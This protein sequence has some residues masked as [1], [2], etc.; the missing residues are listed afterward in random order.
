[1]GGPQ[2][3][4]EL[5]GLARRRVLTIIALMIL[6]HIAFSGGRLALSLFAIELKATAF[7]VGAVV[8]LLS[9][10]P[11]FFSVQVGRWSDRIGIQ[12]PALLATA[13]VTAGILLPGVAPSIAAICAASMLV[14]SGFMILH[15]ATNNAVGHFSTPETRTQ[16]F[17]W[18][19][20]GFSVSTV[21]GPVIAGYA[22][23]HLGHARACLVLSVFPCLALMHY[24]LRPF[25]PPDANHPHPAANHGG[26][27]E[28]LLDRRIRSV[29][30]VSG[31]LNMSWDMF[32]FMFP[33]Y[34][35]S[36]RLSASNIGLVMGS[37]GVATF[38]V[39]LTLP[40]LFRRMG[41]WQVL[42]LGLASAALSFALFPFLAT[43]PT[44]MALSFILGLG[45]GATQ[46]MVLS[47]IHKVA[48]TG[49]TG[50]AIGL[51]TSLLNASQVFLPLIFG[52]F[53]AA[54]GMLPAFAT[55]AVIGAW[56]SWFARNTRHRESLETAPIS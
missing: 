19:A 34:G 13:L 55:M 28:L 35:A 8:S 49:R 41:E 56:G 48:P 7:V 54:A 18:L 17:S 31:L 39:R 9:L 5:K 11:M 1:M 50:E 33:V 23:D 10:L 36:I 2:P 12:R 4:G 37:F 46:P 15:I 27:R 38:V 22:I 52:A 45:L 14:G 24:L 53:S 51:R 32:T 42:S 40:V 16:A 26:V 6:T 30:I 25:G 21:S 43:V 29:F 47:L 20:V 3:Q 44:L